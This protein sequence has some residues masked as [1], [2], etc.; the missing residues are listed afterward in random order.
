MASANP[1]NRDNRVLE[2]IIKYLLFELEVKQ[3]DC[4]IPRF[5]CGLGCPR[6]LFNSRETRL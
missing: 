2:G 3:L 6:A 1:L 4:V 5:T